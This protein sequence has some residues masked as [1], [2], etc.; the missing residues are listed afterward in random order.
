M[1]HIRNL[2]S[3][4]LACLAMEQVSNKA[5]AKEEPSIA[6]RDLTS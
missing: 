6:V 2:Y 5:D 1:L 4:L 3:F